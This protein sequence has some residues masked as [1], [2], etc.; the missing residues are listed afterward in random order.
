[1]DLGRVPFSKRNQE[2]CFTLTEIKQLIRLHGSMS[3]KPKGL[4]RKP[5]EV[6]AIIALGRER[7]LVID[8]K[9]RM[10]RLMR[11]Q[12]VSVLHQRE[13]IPTPPSPLTPPSLPHL[14]TP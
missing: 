6:L 5:D 14:N 3:A 11:K 13:S 7:L 8:E 12:L 1:M 9:I 4:K 2:I 10:F